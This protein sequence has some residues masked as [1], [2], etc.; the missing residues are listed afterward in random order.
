MEEQK[1][2]EI[3]SNPSLYKRS[4]FIE[5]NNLITRSI[6]KFISEISFSIEITINE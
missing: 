3:P 2:A 1:N 6:S 4:Y 5:K